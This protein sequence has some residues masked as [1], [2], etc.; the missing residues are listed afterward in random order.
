MVEAMDRTNAS[1]RVVSLTASALLGTLLLLAPTTTV[2]QPAPSTAAR[3]GWGY[4]FQVQLWHYD[5]VARSNVIGDVSQSG[6]N[7][8]TEQIEWDAVELDPGNYDWS[9]LDNIVGDSSAAGLNIMLSFQ[10]APVF[11]RSDTSG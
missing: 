10:H 7:W 11:Y 6:F 1:R 3:N 4:G 9:Q 5:T 8:L 2:A